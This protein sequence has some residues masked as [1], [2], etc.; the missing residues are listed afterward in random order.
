[1]ATNTQF[2]KEYFINLLDLLPKG[3]KLFL[4][5]TVNCFPAHPVHFEKESTLQGKN[6]LPKKSKFFP[7]RADPFSE[8]GQN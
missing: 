4:E 3:D 6:L 8:G 1:M 5:L 2:I 7:L